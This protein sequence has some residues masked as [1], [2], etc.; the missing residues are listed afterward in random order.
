MLPPSLVWM[1][2]NVSEL[3]RIRHESVG[4][5]ASSEEASTDSGVQAVVKDLRLTPRLSTREHALLDHYVWDMKLALGEASRVLRSGGRAVYVVGESTVRG[6]FIR[7]SAIVTAVAESH[8]LSLVS[9]QSRTLPSNRR[10]LPP[11]KRDAD[12]AAMDGRMTREVVLVFKKS[13]A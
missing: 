11:P 9:R 6:T 8:G 4:S 7:N 3:R 13:A 12:E 5:E 1:G 2:H 10:Y